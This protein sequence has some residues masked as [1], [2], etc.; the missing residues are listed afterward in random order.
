[1]QIQSFV[2]MIL[3]TDSPLDDISDSETEDLAGLKIDDW[4]I[5]QM[6]R[7]VRKHCSPVSL[8]NLVHVFFY[9]HLN[10]YYRY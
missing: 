9:P 5:F 4:L 8:L 2:S 6:E 10:D 3:P 1:M 7:E